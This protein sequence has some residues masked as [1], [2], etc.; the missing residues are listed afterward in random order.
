MPVE[1]I[2]R[3]KAV[4]CITIRLGNQNDRKKDPIINASLFYSIL[5][6]VKVAKIQLSLSVHFIVFK[7]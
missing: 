2:N 4:F 5:T 3:E 1:K 7:I 6:S